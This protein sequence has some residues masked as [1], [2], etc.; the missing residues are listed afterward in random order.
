MIIKQEKEILS[1]NNNK[2]QLY[3][4]GKSIAKTRSTVLVIGVFHGDEPEGEF[5]VKNLMQEIEKDPGLT[6][7]NN[8]L[9]IPCLNPDGKH[10]NTRVNSNGVDINRNFPTK[11]R[12][13][14]EKNDE[15]NAG[16]EPASEIETRFIIDIMDEY[17]PNRILAIHSPYKVINYDGPA[18]EIAEKMS[19]F[20]GYP[21]QI[22]IGY[23][24]PGSFGTYA[25]K[26]RNIPIITLELPENCSLENLWLENKK[27]LYY[28]IYH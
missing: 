3:S 14:P 10:K 7:S 16:P 22:D 26:E 20:N 17:N 13:D 11:N 27:A 8:V 2:I 18:D 24:T 28:F 4:A 5:L 19:K 6:G 23:P 12:I 15:F 21:V 9:F 25:G 1:P